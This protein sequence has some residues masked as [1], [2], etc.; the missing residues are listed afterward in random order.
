MIESE[1]MDKLTAKLVMEFFRAYFAILKETERGALAKFS[2]DNRVPKWI[3]SRILSGDPNYEP[4]MQTILNILK[5]IRGNPPINV[6]K[7][8][9]LGVKSAT[10]FPIELLQGGSTLAGEEIDLL[11]KL[12]DVLSHKDLLDATL[13]NTLLS[14]LDGIHAQLVAILLQTKDGQPAMSK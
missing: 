7:S 3:I 14:L 5:G 10:S 13:I 12:A 2:R 1:N 9:N 4:K 8:L 11:F 6:Q